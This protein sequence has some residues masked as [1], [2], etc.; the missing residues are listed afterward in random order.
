MI[1][2]LESPYHLIVLGAAV[3]PTRLLNRALARAWPDRHERPEHARL[4]SA[5]PGLFAQ[6]S[7]AALPASY[8]PSSRARSSIISRSSRSSSSRR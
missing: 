8:P 3:S 5:D 7:A 2:P 4:V 6:P 1:F